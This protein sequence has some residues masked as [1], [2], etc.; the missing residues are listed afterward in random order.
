MAARTFGEVSQQGE[1]KVCMCIEEGKEKIE[2]ASNTINQTSFTYVAK[3]YIKPKVTAYLHS[4]LHIA[5]PGGRL[6]L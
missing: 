4:N 1:R 2:R 6:Y 3:R 5:I